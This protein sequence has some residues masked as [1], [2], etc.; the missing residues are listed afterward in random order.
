MSLLDSLPDDL[1]DGGLLEV[2]DNMLLASI[3][4][5]EQ[6]AE[7]Q[8]LLGDVQV[9]DLHGQ[10]T[11]VPMSSEQ[12]AQPTAP[13]RRRRSAPKASSAGG[14]VRTR[15]QICSA[16]AKARWGP[17][18][19][20]AAANDGGDNAQGVAATLPAQQ[21]S[22]NQLQLVLSTEDAQ[23]NALVL[24]PLASP[25]PS[26]IK[27]STEKKVLKAS[28]HIASYAAIGRQLKV[29]PHTVQRKMRLQ[30]AAIFFAYP[31]RM[32]RTVMTTYE[33]LQ[34]ECSDFKAVLHLLKHR[35]DEFM[36][37]LRLSEVPPDQALWLATAQKRHRV[38]AKLEQIYTKHSFL[39]RANGCHFELEAEVPTCL[40]PLASVHAECVLSVVESQER[41]NEWSAQTFP[42]RGRMTVADN[43]A[44]NGVADYKAFMKDWLRALLRW[45]CQLHA[46][47]KVSEIQWGSFP[48]DL[49]GVMASTMSCSSPGAFSQWKR[50]AK[51]WI[52]AKATRELI[53]DVGPLSPDAADYRDKVFTNFLHGNEE[54]LHGPQA[55]SR[56]ANLLRKKQ[57]YT[58]DFRLLGVV[59][60]LCAGVCC[61]DIEDTRKMMCDDV[62]LEQPPRQWAEN[63][64]LGSE[65]SLDHHMFWL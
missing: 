1:V 27:G 48:G 61:Q 43:H 49:R 3:P 42:H 37:A 29:A 33:F 30:A 11:Q 40:K 59:P 45:I 62:D 2:D 64:W 4:D 13:K 28:K 41:G 54:R 5:M 44:S 63:R 50:G 17:H 7:M 51:V 55:K 56:T 32:W 36:I 35:F 23:S 22:Q 6:D 9:P 8:M 53:S 26:H 31:H 21:I 60:H 16:A 34:R 52:N 25:I 20:R 65:D 58:G 57:I 39:F 19:R 14:E 12:P 24:A 38:M 10:A 46:G 15:A 18:R 47:H